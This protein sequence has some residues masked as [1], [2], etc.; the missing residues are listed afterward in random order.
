VRQMLG[1]N[2]PHLLSSLILSL[3]HS[4]LSLKQHLI[5]SVWPQQPLQH[6]EV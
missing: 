4:H 2:K 6:H 3:C 5:D 1:Y